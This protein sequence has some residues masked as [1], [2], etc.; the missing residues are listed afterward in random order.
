MKNAKRSR[1]LYSSADDKPYKLSRSN[2]ELFV[3]CPKCFYIDRKHGVGRPPGY[4]F[5]LNSAVDALLKKEFDQYRANGEPH[6]LMVENKIDAIPFAH[7][8]LDKWRE[9]FVGIQYHHSSTNFMITGAVDDIWVNPLGELIVIDYKATSKN[10]EIVTLDED[11]HLG[12]KRQMEIY[13]WL[14]RQIGFKVSNTGYWVYANGDKSRE[15]FDATMHFRMTVIPYIGADDWVES[16]I[17]KIK[18]CLD[19][20]MMPVSNEEC[21][22]CAYRVAANKVDTVK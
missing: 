1:N 8:D 19:D 6:P 18:K 7:P 22:Y 16:C 17:L 12:Y 20:D 13:Q 5:N 9:N 11:W 2:I 3:D 15:R 4:P 21:S 14:L 10:D